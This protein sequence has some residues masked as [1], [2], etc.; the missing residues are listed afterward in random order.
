MMSRQVTDNRLRD[1]WDALHRLVSAHVVNPDVSSAAAYRG[2]EV[3]RKYSALLDSVRHDSYVGESCMLGL[4]RAPGS[5]DRHHAFEGGLT[6]H[7]LEMWECWLMLRGQIEKNVPR[8]DLINDSLILRAI[9]HH[10]LNKV[11]RYRLVNVEGFKMEN[12]EQIRIPW[13]VEYAKANEDPLGHLLPSTHKSLQI[14]MNAG[15][16]LDPLLY[17]ALIT[18]EGGFTEGPRPKTETV[19]AKLVYLLDELSANV[20]SR[21]AAD[22]F[23]DSKDGGLHGIAL[24]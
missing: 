8:H 20:F 23:W 21:I 11:H 9:I 5:K 14:L 16:T 22:R 12:D 4:Y 1:Q 15:I 24:T 19:L 17:N 6:A 18:A 10:D 7:L 2:V 13:E 3:E